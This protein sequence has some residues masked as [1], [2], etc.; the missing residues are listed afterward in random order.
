MS[1]YIRY[2]DERSVQL[3]DDAIDKGYFDLGIKLYYIALDKVRRYQGDRMGP[4]LFAS[5]LISKIEQINSTLSQ[6]VS[7]L[8][9][10]NWK[11]SKSSFIK[12]KQCH[13]YLFLLLLRFLSKSPN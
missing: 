7:S 4:M 12:G 8:G 9:H 1:D 10:A 11:L 5:N 3:G 2:I 13:K 6:E